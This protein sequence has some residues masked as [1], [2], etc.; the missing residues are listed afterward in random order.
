MLLWFTSAEASQLGS[1]LTGLAAILAVLLAPKE[2]KNWRLQKREEKIA[3]AAQ[4]AYSRLSRFLES[5]R[6]ITSPFIRSSDPE[7]TPQEKENKTFSFQSTFHARTEQSEKNIR[8]FLDTWPDVEAL[9]PIEASDLF[10][11]AWDHWADIRANF[12]TYCMIYQQGEEA[13]KAG[14]IHY[15]K[16]LGSEV[17]T[18]IDTL[19]AKSKEVFS[20]LAQFNFDTQKVSNNQSKEN[21]SKTENK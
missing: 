9:L 8:E 18:K 1:F 11:E 13:I 10:K 6:F 16:S 2:I 7:Q 20:P 12:S 15:Q 21:L 4:L 14:Q 17:R 5:L 3:E 19:K